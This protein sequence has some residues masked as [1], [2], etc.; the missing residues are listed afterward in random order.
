MVDYSLTAHT[1]NPSD[2]NSV[3]KIYALPQRRLTLSIEDLADHI[4]DHGSPY[5]ADIIVGV[6]RKLVS[7]IRE[8]LLAGNNVELGRMG[9]FAIAFSKQKGV[10]DANDFDPQTAIG[11]VPVRWIRSKY[12]VDLKSDAKF[13][14]VQTRK[15]QAAARKEVKEALNEEVGAGNSGGGDEPGGDEPGG[16]VTE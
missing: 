14:L 8:Q 3:Q 4:Q 10:D 16:D 7:C 15:E 12:F 5:T 13:Q 9:T 6:A 1:C 11:K 2:K